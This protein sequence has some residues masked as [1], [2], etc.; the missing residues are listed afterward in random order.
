M[1]ALLGLITRTSNK[2]IEMVVKSECYFIINPFK[3]KEIKKAAVPNIV[4]VKL[5]DRKMSMKE[6]KS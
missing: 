2:I 1:F 5:A 6:E 4:S 3:K